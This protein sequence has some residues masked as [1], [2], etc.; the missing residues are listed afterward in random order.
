[1]LDCSK[2]NTKVSNRFLTPK[3]L[4]QSY[5]FVA[6]KCIRA[7]SGLFSPNLTDQSSCRMGLVLGCVVRILHDDWLIRSGENWPDE[8]R[9]HLV[10]KLY[11]AGFY[12]CVSACL[13]MQQ[14]SAT[15]T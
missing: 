2:S 8:A 4:D 10:A 6:A 7:Q 15:Q 9:K 12:I 14:F 5:T 11:V 13:F 3:K 1:M